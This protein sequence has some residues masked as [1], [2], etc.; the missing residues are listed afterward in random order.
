[1]RQNRLFDT[2]QRRK[3]PFRIELRRGHKRVPLMQNGLQR[4]KIIHVQNA[5]LIKRLQGARFDNPCIHQ[6]SLNCVNN[7]TC[8]AIC[9]HQLIKVAI[10]IQPP[11]VE[12]L[13]RQ[14]P[15]RKVVFAN[16][17][18]ALAAQVIE[19]PIF[20]ILSRE[21]QRANS[22]KRPIIP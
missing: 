4:R 8:V 22:P 18:Y 12:L 10:D 11:S 20:G 15:T 14:P 21:N 13:L 19:R 1:M 2:R 16:S 17:H 6:S 3:H 9:K 5:G 7:F